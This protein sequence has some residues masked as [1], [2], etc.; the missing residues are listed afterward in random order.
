M[1]RNR[2]HEIRWEGCPVC[3][4]AEVSPPP[5]AQSTY[6]IDCLACGRFPLQA[7][8]LT[9]GWHRRQKEDWEQLSEGLRIYLH[10]T[11]AERERAWQKIPQDSWIEIYIISFQTWRIFAKKGL[12]ISAPRL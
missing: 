11:K 1:E 6:I 9:S 12:R 8:L 3:G 7:E 2:A 4:W 5:T 10:A